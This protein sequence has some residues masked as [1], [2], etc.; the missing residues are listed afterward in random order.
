[1]TP[2]STAGAAPA[3][4]AIPAISALPQPNENT[5]PHQRFNS[6]RLPQKMGDGWPPRDYN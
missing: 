5:A 2:F 3:E 1:M 4:A 6:G